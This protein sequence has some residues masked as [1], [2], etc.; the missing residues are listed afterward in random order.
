MS[1][2]FAYYLQMFIVHFFELLLGMEWFLS[3]LNRLLIVLH[4]DFCN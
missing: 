1:K 4:S 3:D 2:Q